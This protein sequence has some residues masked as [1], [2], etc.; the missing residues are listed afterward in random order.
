MKMSMCP[1]CHKGFR[2]PEGEAGEHGCPSCGWDMER[3]DEWGKGKSVEE[4]G[5][6]VEED[7]T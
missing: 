6:E 3:E 4:E 2:E 1:R 7:D 5:E